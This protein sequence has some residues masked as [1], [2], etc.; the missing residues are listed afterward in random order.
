MFSFYPK[1][2]PVLCAAWLSQATHVSNVLGT[3]R[4]EWEDYALFDDS[5]IHLW[6]LPDVDHTCT[7]F[8]RSQCSDTQIDAPEYYL[9]V[10]PPQLSDTTPDVAA[11]RRAPA[12]SLYYWSL[13]PTGDSLMPEAQRIALGLPSFHQSIHMLCPVK[14]HWKAEIYDLARQWQEAQ[15]FDPTTT[16]FARSMGRP[17]VEI[18][19]QDD[20]RFK[21][22][23]E[24][25]EVSILV[26]S[27][28]ESELERMEVDEY[29]EIGSSSQGAL[30]SQ[31]QFEESS[32]M[33][34]DMEDC[35]SLMAN[36]QVE[37]SLMDE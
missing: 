17:L 15:G 37:A 33:D 28:N 25:D 27:K 22:C 29:F 31:G 30:L 1:K 3:P 21:N 36:L 18:L 20:G 8:N 19:P 24:D 4:E 7:P 2:G 16:N 12:E 14:H 11:W 9:F 32:S 6:L 5:D 35:S 26:D 13:D 10:L 34:V 23:V